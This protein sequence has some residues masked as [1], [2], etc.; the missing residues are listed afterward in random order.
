M[1]ISDWSSY[2]CSSD[3]TQFLS[4]GKYPTMLLSDMGRDRKV[5]TLEEAHWRLSHMSAS[6]IGLEG[7]G[8]LERGMPAAIVVYDMEKPGIVTE[9]PVFEPITGGGKRFIQRA[10]GYRS[11]YAHGVPPCGWDECTGQLTGRCTWTDTRE[12]DR[13]IGE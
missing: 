8:T 3:L 12:A 7:I 1:R 9:S 10:V 6:A 5:M 13:R 2:V 11:I 4:M